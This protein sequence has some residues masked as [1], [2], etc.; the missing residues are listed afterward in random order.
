[1]VDFKGFYPLERAST[2]VSGHGTAIKT[3]AFKGTSITIGHWLPTLSADYFALHI[4]MPA[5]GEVTSFC[6]N[7]V[8]PDIAG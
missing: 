6:H 7:S 8:R 2:A 3:A 5:H 4:Y 1:V